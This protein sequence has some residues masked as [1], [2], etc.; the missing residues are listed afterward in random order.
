MKDAETGVEYLLATLRPYFVKDGAPLQLGPDFK[1]EIARQKAVDA[2][3]DLTT[4][5]PDPAGGEVVA[6]IQRSREAAGERLRAE[7]RQAYVGAPAGLQAHVN[8]V[9]LPD[10]TPA[11]TEAAVETVWRSQR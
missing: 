8:A 9:A 7:A 1:R 4:P 5:R 3:L 11:M 2:W 10:E 6:E